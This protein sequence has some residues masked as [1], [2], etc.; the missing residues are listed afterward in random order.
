LLYEYYTG[1]WA[2]KFERERLTYLFLLFPLYEESRS[3]LVW[4][5]AGYDDKSKEREREI[6]RSHAPTTRRREGDAAIS[7]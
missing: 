4:S 2:Q 3:F 1:K 6:A 7:G 5:F